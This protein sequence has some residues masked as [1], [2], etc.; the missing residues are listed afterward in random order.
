MANIYFS[1]TL[2]WDASIEEILKMAKSFDVSGIELWAQHFESRE[3][4]V[5]EYLEAADFYQIDTIV[6]S[7]SWDLNFASLNQGIRRSSLDEIRKS[8]ELA[9]RIGAEEVT[10]HPPRQTLNMAEPCFQQYGYLGL[11]ELVD[12]AES[13]GI[14]ISLEVMEEKPGEFVTSAHAVKEFSRDLYKRLSYTMDL[15]HCKTMEFFE[16]QCR[17]LDRISKIHISNKK[18]KRLH[19]E[20]AEGDYDFREILPRLDKK[21]VPLVIEGFEQGKDFRKIIGNL[22]LIKNIRKG[23]N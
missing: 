19:T 4:D 18:G 22:E 5:D 2:M 9:E 11:V 10:V 21:G 16:E 6:H 3:Y 1:S 15:A 23:C 14:R 13:L 8:I 7:K 12:Y 20:L 17:S